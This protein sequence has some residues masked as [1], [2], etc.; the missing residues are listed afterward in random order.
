MSPYLPYY[1]LE[2][3]HKDRM[4]EFGYPTGEPLPFR[5]RRRPSRRRGRITAGRLT[6]LLRA[7]PKIRPG[8]IAPGTGVYLD[9]LEP[10]YRATP[11]SPQY[12]AGSSGT[13]SGESG[14]H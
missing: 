3:L 14:R 9:E 2:V 12:L 13:S 4:R 5:A 8:T 6:R 10:S 7:Y 1:V 11:A